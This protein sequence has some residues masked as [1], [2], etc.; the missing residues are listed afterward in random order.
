MLFQWLKDTF[1]FLGIRREDRD[2]VRVVLVEIRACICPLA[3]K[4][5]A[6][7]Y[8]FVVPHPIL[9][10]GEKRVCYGK[11]APRS[12]LIGRSVGLCQQDTCLLEKAA[13]APPRRRGAVLR[14]SP[15]HTLKCLL[16]CCVD[17]GASP[18]RMEPTSG[19]RCRNGETDQPGST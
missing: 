11:P 15:V 13:V 3:N 2:S 10:M 19:I 16:M 17:H 6:L 4:Q 14:N 8:L 7:S 18:I 9:C 5:V 12:P 1:S